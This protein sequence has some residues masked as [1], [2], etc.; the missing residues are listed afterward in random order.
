MRRTET[1]EKRGIPFIPGI[2]G[3]PVLPH[4]ERAMT[5]RDLRPR[6]ANGRIDA[7]RL[8]HAACQYANYLWMR[9]LPARAILALCRALYLN[10]ED[11]NGKPGQ[12]YDAFVWILRQHDGRGFLGNPRVSFSH[13]ATRIPESMILKRYRAWALW[14]LT[15]KVMPD[16]PPDPMVAET[17][18]D[19]QALV[20][21]LDRRGLP[22]EGRLFK[23]ALAG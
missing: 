7:D 19:P 22:E 16:L 13:Q 1:I 6:L 18:P 11:L 14:H 20:S 5:Y 12:P 4:P 17:P 21:F 2:K 3:C 10:P 9:G 23:A 8:H 15:R